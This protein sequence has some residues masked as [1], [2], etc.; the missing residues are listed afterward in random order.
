[1]EYRP[2]LRTLEEINDEFI[3]REGVTR[4]MVLKFNGKGI[5]LPLLTLNVKL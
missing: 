2:F 1:M 4:F 3:E 5:F